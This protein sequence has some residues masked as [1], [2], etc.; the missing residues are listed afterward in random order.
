MQ[1]V[2][3]FWWPVF[4]FQQE[5]A[6]AQLWMRPLDWQE[7]SGV[8]WRVLAGGETSQRPSTGCAILAVIAWAV[9]L[10]ALL[11]WGKRAGRLVGLC[12]GIPL[13]GAIAYALAVRN[14]L[15]ERYLVFAHIFLL[16]GCA[17][18]ISQIRWPKVRSVLSAAVLAWSGFWCWRFS[19]TL[20]FQAGFPGVRGAVAYL[21]Q[22]R[23]P[24]DLV[25]VSWPFVYPTVQ[26]HTS[27][28]ERIVVQYDGDH[29]RD[30]LAGPPLRECECVRRLDLAAL[31]E[32]RVCTV[33]VSTLFKR[34]ISVELLHRYQLVGEARFAERFRQAKEIVVRQWP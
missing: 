34:T 18:L 5:R 3:A 4:Q 11:I 29:R 28:P 1:I 21:D 17:L 12:T 33:D 25:I 6:N 20:E 2:W 23:Q 16:V 26:R 31:S 14:I 13:A 19:Q 27:R 15:G 32:D 7:L 8:C 10:L 30:I 9:C 22:K 24:N